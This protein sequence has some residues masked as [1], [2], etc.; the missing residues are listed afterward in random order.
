MFCL[1]DSTPPKKILDK[2]ETLIE[3]NCVPSALLH[4]GT[5]SLSDNYLKPELFEK[6][7]TG[8]SASLV[9]FTSENQSFDQASGSNGTNKKP[10]VP[11]NFMPSKKSTNE[12]TGAIPKWFKKGK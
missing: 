8:A 5:S 2:N 12:A 10:M 7:S 1:S 9:L 11:Q 3:S 4:F 6:L